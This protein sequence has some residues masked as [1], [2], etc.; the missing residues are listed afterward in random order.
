MPGTLLSKATPEFVEAF[1]AADLV[2][3]KGQGNWET[4]EDCDRKVFFLLQAKCPGVAKIKGCRVD[5]PLLIH[6]P[7]TGDR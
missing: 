1:E 6:E 3:S 7:A 2:I 5:S 4:L